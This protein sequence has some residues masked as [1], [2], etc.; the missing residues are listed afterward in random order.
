MITSLYAAVLAVW[1]CYLSVQVIKQRRKHQV[2]HS[3]GQVKELAIARSAHSNATE[4]IPI[5]L[6]L[7][8]L[9]EFNGASLWLIHLLGVVFIVGRAAHG[10][11]VLNGTMQG[12]KYG[13]IATFATI[14]VLAVLNVLQVFS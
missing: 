4:Y 2:S 10:F 14:V 8:M 5:G 3:D 13:M 9:A 12:R 11:A 1:I 7:L 6:L